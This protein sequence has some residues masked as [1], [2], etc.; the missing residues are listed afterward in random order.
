MWVQGKRKARVPLGAI[1]EGMTPYPYLQVFP[2]DE[3]ERLLIERLEAL[4]V[5]VE[6]QR[7]LVEFADDGSQ[8]TARI[9]APEGEEVCEASYIVGCDGGHSTVRRQMGEDFPGGT[10]SRSSTSPILKEVGR[11]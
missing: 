11:P 5:S 1:G 3:H 9:R 7:E 6:R 10:Y 4:G 2:Q 8:I